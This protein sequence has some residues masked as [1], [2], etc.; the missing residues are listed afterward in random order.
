MNEF[1]SQYLENVVKAPLVEEIQIDE[2]TQV[3]YIGFPKDAAMSKCRIERITITSN[4]NVRSTIT[5]IVDYGKFECHWNNRAVL[6]YRL[7]TV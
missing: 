1:S 5:E 3:I 7:K 6:N 4:G 2:S